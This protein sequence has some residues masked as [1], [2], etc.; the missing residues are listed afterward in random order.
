[1]R[2]AFFFTGFIVLFVTS[3]FGREPRWEKFNG[4]IPP[5]AIWV[6]MEEKIDNGKTRNLYFCRSNQNGKYSIGKV[7][8]MKCKFPLNGK[9][10]VLDDY[11]IFLHG[12]RVKFIPFKGSV[13]SKSYSFEESPNSP[14]YLC[15]TRQNNAWQPGRFMD[16]SCKI[17]LDGKEL[18]S[19]Q[20]LFVLVKLRE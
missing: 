18:S 14:V 10:V 6:G 3:V 20:S 8:D 16:N 1:M 2:K 13:H 4:K 5:G 11:E 15:I 7:V 17:S 9:E 19:N 12:S